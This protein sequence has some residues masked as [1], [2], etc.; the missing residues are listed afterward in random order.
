M[1]SFWEV[2]GM[3]HNKFSMYFHHWHAVNDIMQEFC[4]EYLDVF[5]PN[6]TLLGD[7]DWDIMEEVWKE[8]SS[9]PEPIMIQ[10]TFDATNPNFSRPFDDFI[11]F[12]LSYVSTPDWEDIER[13]VRIDAQLERAKKHAANNHQ[14]AIESTE[15]RRAA[16]E[17]LK[18]EFAK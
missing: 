11:I 10:A 2:E 5:Q 3:D 17:E 8:G 15:R 18:K 1:R 16:Y 14:Q 13:Q 4:E 9:T 7:V 12:P 6:Y